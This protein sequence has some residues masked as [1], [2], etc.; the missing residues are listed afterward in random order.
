HLLELDLLA[1][2]LLTDA[3]EAFD[4]AVDLG[5]R[6]L[7]FSQLRRERLLELLDHAFSRAP[8]PV[9]LRA[10]SLVFDRLEVSKRQLLQLVFH[11]ANPK[12]VCD[13]RIDVTRLLRDGYAAVVWQVVQRPHV[14]KAVGELDEDHTDVVDHR[15]QHLPEAL[16]L[17]LFARRE[18]DGADFRD[19]LDNV[20]NLRTEQFADALDRRQRVLDDVVEEARGD[21]D[22]VQLHVGKEVGDGQ[23]MDQVRF[24]GVTDLA[25][26]FECRKDVGA[27]QQLDVG[28]RTVGPDFFQQIFESNHG[29]RCLT[30]YRLVL[31]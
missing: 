28:V 13:R 7:R 18:R 30:L 22:H 29:K 27:P 25:P 10:Q 23:G 9:D 19:A 26:V 21:R 5:D 6:H 12:T 11:F 14:V 8:S 24:A 16:R 4:A 31:R 2:Q 3:P 20:R 15:Q 1:L 17:P